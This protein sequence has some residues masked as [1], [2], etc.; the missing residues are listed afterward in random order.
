M[1]ITSITKAEFEAIVPMRGRGIKA[2]ETRALEA[3]E[4]GVGFKVPCSRKH[5]KTT[6]TGS[7][8][9]HHGARRLGFTI[10]TRCYQSTLYVLRIT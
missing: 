4:A 1:T 3:L 9:L 8:L 7:Q 2:P 5:A 6:C 10:E